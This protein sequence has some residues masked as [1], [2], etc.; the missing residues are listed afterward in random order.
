M[1]VLTIG[2][3]GEDV[4]Q[5]ELFLRGQDYP[6]IANGVFDEVDAKSTRKYQ[7]REGLKADGKPGPQ[8]F[9]HAILEDCF[10]PATDTSAL[11]AGAIDRYSAQW[12]PRP[13]YAPLKGN[14]A[15]QRL[16]GKFAYEHK[17]TAR[18]PEKIIVD[19]KWAKANIVTVK[20]P[21]P[22][23]RGRQ[24][25]KPVKSVRVHR[26]IADQFVA[27]MRRIQVSGL[28]EKIITWN[29]SYVPRFV[30]GSTKTLSNHSF[31]TAFDIN[32]G[33]NGL[34]QTPMLAGD[35]GSVRELVPIANRHGFY[36]GGHYQRR[37]DGMHFEAAKVL[38]EGDLL[39]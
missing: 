2:S 36:W 19:P 9:A 32:V 16:F 34:N 25:G 6:V 26:K 3:R 5:W 17:P 11:E 23:A 39:L 33:W 15:R 4:E 35:Y 18:N 31:G 12:P 14:A 27:M 10:D 21:F 30:R 22:I 29:G 13:D 20:L 38:R 28:D 8:T 24:G 37:L 1:R 7:R